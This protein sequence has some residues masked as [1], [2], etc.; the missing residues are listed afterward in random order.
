MP[1]FP[2]PDNEADRL[3]A[4]RSYNILDTAEEDDFDELTTL[5]SAI[6]QTPIALIS[7]VDDSRQWFK[8]H[9]GLDARETPKNVSFCAH[10]IASPNEVMM[11]NDASQDPRFTENSLVTG[12]PHVIFYAGV[13][14]VTE[15]GFAL[16]SLCVI[17]HT[18]KELTAEQINALKILAK[19]VI[20]KLDLRRKAETL[21]KAHQ[22]L[23]SSNAFIEKFASMAAHDIKNPLS[24]MLLSSQALR[25][26][27]AKMQDAGCMKL[28]DL[29]ITSIN[30]LMSMLDE[31]L[32]YSK[33][34][35][36]LLKRKQ[37]IYLN[38]ILK[39]VIGLIKVPANFK[40]S[41]PE[42]G[43]QVNVSPIATEQIFI[44][45][46]TNAIRYNDKEEGLI[47]IRFSYDDDNY[48][49][50]VEDNGIGIDEKHFDDIFTNNFT[51]NKADRFDNSGTGI[52]LSTVKEIINTLGG[53][54][55]LTSAIGKGTTFY[56]SIPK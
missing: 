4:L 50:E 43:Y 41:L 18:P 17:D 52:G 15:D 36:T 2:L 31:M 53:S 55:S 47:D 49:F 1:K 42:D 44:N 30:R 5:A 21:K 27:L 7:L 35:D 12:E 20:N 25:M 39:Q 22:Q 19:Q 54:I 26:R 32:A 13:P 23:R 3:A 6:C 11:V 8:S 10:A 40:I 24:S 9:K 33:S 28:I 34:P 56:V 45:L 29:N 46:L 14:L 16:G 48:L 38:D 51:L 37:R